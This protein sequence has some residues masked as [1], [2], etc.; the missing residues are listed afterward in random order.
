M[1]IGV[2]YFI[3][4]PRLLI[5]TVW[6]TTICMGVGF[7]VTLLFNGQLKRLNSS[8]INVQY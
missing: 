4:H 7:L 6:S 3:E 2:N 8:K 5:W 1:V